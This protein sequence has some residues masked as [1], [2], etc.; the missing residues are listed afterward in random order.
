MFGR[1]WRRVLRRRRKAAAVGSV[2]DPTI[3]GDIIVPP[4]HI[5]HTHM[6]LGHVEG[7]L[8]RSSTTT[9]YPMTITA[10][11]DRPATSLVWLAVV[12]GCRRFTSS[13]SDPEPGTTITGLQVQLSRQAI[14]QLASHN[15]NNTIMPSLPQ[16]YILQVIGDIGPL[17]QLLLTLVDDLTNASASFIS[18]SDEDLGLE[19]DNASRV[20]YVHTLLVRTMMAANFIS[21]AFLLEM[22]QGR[23]G[24]QL[25]T[26]SVILA[27]SIY[28]Q[29]RQSH[30]TCPAVDHSI[31][32]PSCRIC[33]QFISGFETFL[34]TH[35]AG[36]FTKHVQKALLLI[37]VQPDLVNYMKQCPP[38]NTT[39][40]VH[41]VIEYGPVVRPTIWNAYIM[42]LLSA[43]YDCAH[44]GLADL[45]SLI[46]SVRNCDIILSSEPDWFM[47]L[48][49]LYDIWQSNS[50]IAAQ[51]LEIISTI[52]THQFVT[53]DDYPKLFRSVLQRAVGSVG[54]EM[55]TRIVIGTI[56]KL[57]RKHFPQDEFDT[58]QW[59][60]LLNLLSVVKE[61]VL[62]KSS[63]TSLDGPLQNVLS[64]SL[65]KDGTLNPIDSTLIK[66]TLRL[67]KVL[68]CDEEYQDST[69]GSPA[70]H[71]LHQKA[72]E[73]SR[74]FEDVQ[75][76]TTLYSLKLRQPSN[77]LAT[78]E[79][80]FEFNRNSECPSKRLQAIGHLSR[81]FSPQ[82]EDT[83]DVVE[84]FLSNQTPLATSDHTGCLS[85]RQIKDVTA[86]GEHWR[87]GGRFTG[88]TGRSLC[89]RLEELGLSRQRSIR[90]GIFLQGT[91]YIAPVI[92]KNKQFM[93]SRDLFT[94]T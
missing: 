21:S 39:T 4:P 53:A 18:K 76:F 63:N 38:F 94:L 51:I 41:P 44:H 36:H 57:D 9:P 79:I 17:P 16:E 11:H 10:H 7:A 47:F 86:V 82:G 88:W 43:P 29:H 70:E 34:R 67:L 62:V 31:A 42:A 56:Q 13:C 14:T 52:Q 77:Y 26:L 30:H 50:V 66:S 22:V 81:L 85:L 90:I 20:R 28:D 89:S 84:T 33:R 27:W 5:N 35:I 59:T 25:Q 60:N 49:A 93:F 83:I 68:G 23:H 55:A 65:G 37:A 32:S 15:P 12:N 48:I 58:K 19:T 1:L 80:M 74:F 73:F 64:L 61:T 24:N 69:P 3:M 46:D 40:S 71:A 45:L 8:N 6:G 78:V 72:A 2:T 91:G 75:L 54:P 92:Y 87:F